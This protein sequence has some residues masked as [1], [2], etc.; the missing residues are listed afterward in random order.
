[1]KHKE[2]IKILEWSLETPHENGTNDCNLTVMKVIDLFAGT[3]IADR[4][5]KTIKQ[6][7]AGL[8]KE[9]WNHTGEIVEAYCDPVE[10]P[11]DGD[12]WLC[13]DNPL[14]MAVVVSERILGVNETHDGFELQR[15][16]TNGRY[17][18]VRKH[19]GKTG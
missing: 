10:V 12:I 18:R 6:G 13:P 7:L 14:V 17:Y 8:K 1:M 3:T 9:G 2:L 19:H 16:P 4:K 5:Y 15:L 11:I